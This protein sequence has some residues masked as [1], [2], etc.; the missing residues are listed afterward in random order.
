[1]HAHEVDGNA[2]QGNGNADQRVDGVGVE[3]DHHQEEG[4]QAEDHWVEQ[5]QLGTTEHTNKIRTVPLHELLNYY[6]HAVSACSEQL[7]LTDVIGTAGCCS[8]SLFSP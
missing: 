5:C 6:K 3:R 8:V 1:M 2:R 4:T 7:M